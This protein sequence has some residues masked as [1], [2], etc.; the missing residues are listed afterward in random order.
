ME[1]TFNWRYHAKRSL[2]RRVKAGVARDR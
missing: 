2:Q 1:S